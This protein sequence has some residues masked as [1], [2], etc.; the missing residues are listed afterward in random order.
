MTHGP[1]ELNVAVA[2]LLPAVVTALSSAR[3]PS[4]LVM[5]RRVDPVPAAAVVVATMFAP[6]IN[7]FATVVVAAPLLALFPLPLAPAVTSNVV[8]PRYS[9][10][11]T[12]GYPAAWF[13]GSLTRADPSDWF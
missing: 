5:I 11:R 2:L 1:E 10:M 6:K 3:S 13:S 4:G 12:S 8:T 7:S 9:R